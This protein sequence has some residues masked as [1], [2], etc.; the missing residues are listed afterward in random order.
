[1]SNRFA[2]FL[3]I[4]IVLGLLAPDQYV[5]AAAV[6]KIEIKIDW[7]PA[8]EYYGIFYAKYAG[9]FK[10]H[11]YDV[12]ITYGSGAPDVATLVGT[13]EIAIGTTTSD[14]ILRRFATGQRYAAVRKIFNF[15]PSSIVTLKGND[16]AS[17]ADL[18]RKKIGVNIQAS[19]YEQFM[20][21]VKK[22]KKTKLLSDDFTEVAIG[23]G[24]S[25]QL[26]NG[27]VD[28]FLAY[29]TNQ[30]ID[31]A[32]ERPDDCK[33]IFLG[34]E[35]IYSYGLVL[36][37][38][39]Q[40]TLEA[41]GIQREDIENI[42]D[43]ISEGYEK[44]FRDIDNAVNYLID[45]EPVINKEKTRMAIQKIGKLNASVVYPHKLVDSWVVSEKV[46]EE[47]RLDVL[48]LYNSIVWDK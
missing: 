25:T 40:K 22:D 26:L 30:A 18:A 15:N 1:M 14:N 24:G 38:A 43:A 48:H 13:G 37:F 41:H 10:K 34:D 32:M 11:G 20:F 3:P 44:G 2:I 19:P 33:E 45:V 8:A 6:K 4:I 47:N 27:M 5:R 21:L 17:V 31:V 36:A 9:I 29:T 16:I 42:Y 7:T 23:F 12:K 28:A 39:D 35:G 46:T